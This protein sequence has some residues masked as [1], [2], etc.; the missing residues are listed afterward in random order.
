[1]MLVHLGDARCTSSYRRSGIGA[2]PMRGQIPAGVF[3]MPVLPEYFISHQWLR[4]L[5]RKGVRTFIGVYFRVSD[6]EPV[7]VGHYRNAH[8]E[9]AAAEAAKLIMDADDPRGYEVIVPR[10]IDS[11]EIKSIRAV[12]RVVGWRYYPEA[13]GKR[14]FCGCPSCTRGEIRARRLR[15]SSETA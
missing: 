9:M 10:R 5:K 12:H 4:E 11:D 8:A 7:L 14:P 3:A 13:K 2:S 15:S 1:M 6:A